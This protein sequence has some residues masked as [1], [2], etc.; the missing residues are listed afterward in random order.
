MPEFQA[1]PERGLEGQVLSGE[2][3]LEEIDTSAFKER[4]G[5]NMEKIEPVAV[6]AAE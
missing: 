1:D 2:I 6:Q 5:G 4:Y 3:Q